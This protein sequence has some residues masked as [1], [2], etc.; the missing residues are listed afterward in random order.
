VKVEF[1]PKEPIDAA[2]FPDELEKL[3]GKKVM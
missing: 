3:D 1:S 2:R